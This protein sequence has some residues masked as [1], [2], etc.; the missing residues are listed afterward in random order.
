MVSGTEAADGDR[1]AFSSSF[2]RVGRSEH[3]A[4]A[5]AGSLT[6]LGSKGGSLLSQV[7]RM[8]NSVGLRGE[9]ARRLA[10]DL[11]E[12]V[13]G[14]AGASLRSMG[15]QISASLTA[16]PAAVAAAGNSFA[17]AM[18]GK[19]HKPGNLGSVSSVGKLSTALGSPRT[20]AGLSIWSASDRPSNATV[21]AAAAA[22]S[23]AL[24]PN[25]DV[26]SPTESPE[27]APEAAPE[28]K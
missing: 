19:A 14:G 25:A 13:S 6:A 24:A 5:R 28:P 8:G 18:A 7:Q 9:S 23:A 26:L 16:D 12:Q 20:S 1:P 17:N 27:E 11:D 4:S 10:T 15:S 22:A 3:A 21:A 2:W